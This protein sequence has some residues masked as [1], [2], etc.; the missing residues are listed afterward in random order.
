M[1]NTPSLD[2]EFLSKLERLEG[3]KLKTIK[4]V[5]NNI[6]LKEGYIDIKHKFWIKK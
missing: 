1:L 4:N 3:I 6:K 5:I 2:Q